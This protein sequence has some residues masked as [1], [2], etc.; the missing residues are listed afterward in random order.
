MKTFQRFFLFYWLQL[1]FPYRLQD[2]S[3]AQSH[4]RILYY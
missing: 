2:S 3:D 1:L 4:F